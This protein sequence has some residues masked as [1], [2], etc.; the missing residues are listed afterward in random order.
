MHQ[1]NLG[2]EVKELIPKEGIPFFL[3]FFIIFIVLWN[4]N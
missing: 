4:K 1:Y 2:P 3:T